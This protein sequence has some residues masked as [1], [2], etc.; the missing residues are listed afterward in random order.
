MTAGRGH[1]GEICEDHTGRKQRN[2]LGGGNSADVDDAVLDL[3]PGLQ[4]G[5]HA[6]QVAVVDL[7]GQQRV[8]ALHPRAVRRHSATCCRLRQG[9]GGL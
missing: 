8:G 9:R 5:R 1:N 2:G 3:R 6:G 7:E 4:V